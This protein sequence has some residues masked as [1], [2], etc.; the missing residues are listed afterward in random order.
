MHQKRIRFVYMILVGICISFLLDSVAPKDSAGHNRFLDFLISIIITIIVWEG[1][2]RIDRLM[3][4]KFPWDQKPAIRILVHAPSS[5][6]FTSIMIYFSMFAF[7]KYVCKLPSKTQDQ[8]MA[9]AIIMGILVSLILLSIEIGSQFF[10]KWKSSLVE[11]EKYKAE[12]LQ[13]QLQNLKDQINPHFM[14]NNLSVLSSLV[15]KDQDKA[16]D[17]INQLSKVYRYLLDSR[18]VELVSLKDELA[19]IHSYNY[20]LQIRFDKNLVFKMDIPESKEHLMLPPMAM[21]MLIEN[22]IKHN[23]ISKEFPLSINTQLVNNK[24]EVSNQLRLRSSPEPSSKT[25]LKN[26][27]ERYKFFT[28]EIVEI[29]ETKEVFTVRIPLLKTK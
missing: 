15:Y 18:S 29:V 24:L 13:A 7:D 2:L 28:E 8:F 3:D 21:Q 23:E 16:V 27:K 9:V 22:A 10:T 26:I 11:V 6:L 20:L 14:F 19:F 1:N 5:L 12:S 17:F 4:K 25:G